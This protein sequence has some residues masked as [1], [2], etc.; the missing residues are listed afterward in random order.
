[1]AFSGFQFPILELTS[2]TSF[3]PPSPFI[4]SSLFFRSVLLLWRFLFLHTTLCCIFCT[5]AANAVLQLYDKS[6]GYLKSESGWHR[7]DISGRQNRQVCCQIHGHD[8]VNCE[9]MFVAFTICWSSQNGQTIWLIFDEQ[10]IK[11]VSV[12]FD[13]FN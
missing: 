13:Y 2:Q 11:N 4:H 5:E 8:S 9:Q 1:L 7:G 10:H 12:T 3:P 6:S